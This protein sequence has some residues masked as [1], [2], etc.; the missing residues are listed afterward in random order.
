RAFVPAR[1][2]ADVARSNPARE[3]PGRVARAVDL[4]PK[5]LVFEVVGL[6]ETWHRVLAGA[7]EPARPAAARQR[8]IEAAERLAPDQIPE[9]EHVERNLQPQLALDVARGVRALAGLVVLDDPARAERVDVDPVDL[10][11]KAHSLAE[12]EPALQLG[13]RALHAERDLEL[14]RLG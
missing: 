4:P 2:V 12:V 10:P 14:P 7:K 8:P 11:G 6:G 3:R 13:G 5:V 9:H 1:V